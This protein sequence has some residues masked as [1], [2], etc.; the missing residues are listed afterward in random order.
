VRSAPCFSDTTPCFY[1]STAVKDERNGAFR[2][3]SFGALFSFLFC[4][5]LL[6]PLHFTYSCAVHFLSLRAF[7]FIFNLCLTRDLN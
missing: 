5:M 1:N 7:L 3:F 4:S 6:L 2:R